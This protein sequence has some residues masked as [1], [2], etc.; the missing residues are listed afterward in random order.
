MDLFGRKKRSR[1]LSQ[2]APEEPDASL[3]GTSS[4]HERIATPDRASLAPAAGMVISPPVNLIPRNR[5]PHED[6]FRYDRQL[7]QSTSDR[8]SRSSRAHSPDQQ[9]VYS[10]VSLPRPDEHAGVSRSRAERSSLSESVSNEAGRFS[11]SR[12]VGEQGQSRPSQEEQGG[13]TSTRGSN[14][15]S[16][17]ARQTP[18]V[19][20]HTSARSSPSVLYAPSPEPSTQSF[21]RRGSAMSVA[22]SS[23]RPSTAYSIRSTSSVPEPSPYTKSFEFHRP[24]PPVIEALFSEMMLLRGVNQPDIANAKVD[25]D[26]K[27]SLVYRWKEE[28]WV[29]AR[30]KLTQKPEG[31]SIASVGPDAR[32]GTKEIPE[33]Y[34]S[35]FLGNTIT[36]GNVVSL[37]ISLRTYDIG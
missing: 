21:P 27:W 11:T 10:V 19:S 2:S 1:V 23:A 22:S 14:Y 26:G 18:S 17:K 16:S 15:G 33:W 35:R 5:P 24:A 20:S 8:A 4:L 7:N 37:S 12:S 6:D 3:S 28:A 13:S 34:I 30:R 9:S 36:P 25:L 29:E 32:G 31:R